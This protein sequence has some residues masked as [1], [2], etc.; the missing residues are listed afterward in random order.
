MDLSDTNDRAHLT[1]T[2]DVLQELACT[3]DV[4]RRA[5]RQLGNLYDDTVASTGLKATQIGM[6]GHIER[7]K[8]KSGTALQPL[9]EAMAISVSALTHALRPLVRDGFVELR[10]DDHD[11]R[12]KRVSLS[13]LGKV[14]FDQ[15]LRLWMDAHKRTET[16]LGSDTAESLRRLAGLV[17]SEGFLIAH[18]SGSNKVGSETN[19]AAPH[20]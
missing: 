7:A 8:G 18:K 5:A 15:G 13:K 14:R 2:A 11:K 9:A 1:G 3:H 20:I 17:A 16:I 6:L 12:I 19:L 10:A 4:L